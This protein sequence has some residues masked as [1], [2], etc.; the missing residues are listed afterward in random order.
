MERAAIKLKLDKLVIQQG[1][2][3]DAS[4]QLMKEEMLNWIRYGANLVFSA[5]SGSESI[6]DDTIEA[7]L[8]RSKSKEDELIG[9]L[10]GLEDSNLRN[11][12]LES[13]IFS[14]E[15]EDYQDKN[16]ARDRAMV[17]PT[18]WIEPPKRERKAAVYA[19]TM[20]Y[21]DSSS[22]DEEWKPKVRN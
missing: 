22:K 10:D 12:A 16:K 18:E 7:I 1:R 13:S 2:L 5:E 3:V 17:A 9:K 19:E 6:P 4:T 11:F 20:F 21:K 14:F 8:E 15:G